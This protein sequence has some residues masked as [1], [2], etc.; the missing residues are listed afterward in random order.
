MRVVGI[1]LDPL[2]IYVVGNCCCCCCFFFSIFS[3]FL[4]HPYPHQQQRQQRQQQQQQ[5]KTKHNSVKY[6]NKIQYQDLT[7]L[8]EN[9]CA[10]SLSASGSFYNPSPASI[11]AQTPCFFHCPGPTPANSRKSVPKTRW[12]FQ[13]IMF[14]F[15][16]LFG[17]D[18]HVDEHI[19][20]R[21]WFNHQPENYYLHPSILNPKADCF[22]RLKNHKCAVQSGMWRSDAPP[23]RW[24]T[25]WNWHV[26]RII[27]YSPKRMLYI[28]CMYY[29]R[30]CRHNYII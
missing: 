22:W 6:N 19:F 24:C 17:E 30:K 11:Q 3:P 26:D 1:R 20:Q 21:G 29:R 2:Y 14:L 13:I 28:L 15:S 23:P 4:P 8:L 10:C 7:N 12:W 9:L 25:F 5:Q 27:D 18:S 16:P